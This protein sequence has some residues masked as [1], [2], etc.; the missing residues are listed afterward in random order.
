MKETKEETKETKEEK[1]NKKPVLKTDNSPFVSRIKIEQKKR[2]Y[3]IYF[4]KM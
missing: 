3:F 1:S 2:K 4:T